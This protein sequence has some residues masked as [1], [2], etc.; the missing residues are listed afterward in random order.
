MDSSPLMIGDVTIRLF[1]VL[2]LVQSGM[3]ESFEIQEA[4][5]YLR[6]SS[7]LEKPTPGNASWSN[8]ILDVK[9]RWSLYDA[10]VPS[11]SFGTLRK[12]LN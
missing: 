9:C 8:N 7:R 3:R 10:R 1:D 12:L 5:Q 4:V 2:R 11:S 6:F